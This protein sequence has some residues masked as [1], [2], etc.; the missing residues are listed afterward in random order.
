[1]NWD[2]RRIHDTVYGGQA[3]LGFLK[4]YWYLGTYQRISSNQSTKVRNFHLLQVPPP[5]KRWDTKQQ[6]SNTKT[7]MYICIIFIYIY[8]YKLRSQDEKGGGM[9]RRFQDLLLTLTPSLF[10]SLSPQCPHQLCVGFGMIIIN[11][12]AAFCKKKHTHARRF[13]LS[14]SR[15]FSSTPARYSAFSVESFRSMGLAPPKILAC[16]RSLAIW[17]TGSWTQRKNV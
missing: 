14:L 16:C 17:F 1:M 4:R 7:Y 11:I 10:F 6:K 5:P 12:Y 3:Q 15:S 13:S 8:I 2:S 9:G